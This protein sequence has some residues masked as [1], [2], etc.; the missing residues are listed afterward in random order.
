M[1]AIQ[2][3]D[4]L[5]FIW[6]GFYHDWTYNHRVNRMGD[7]ISD[8][9]HSN[10]FKAKFNHSAA[11]GI[12]GD[13]LSYTTFVTA[14]RTG[15]D[16]NFKAGTISTIVQ[17]SEGDAET[18]YVP[19]QVI[20][21]DAHFDVAD[22]LL[23]GFDMY[24][25][26]R[27]S[28][29]LIGDGQADKL[30]FLF[31]NFHEVEVSYEGANTIVDFTTRISVGG[32]CT[33]PECSNNNFFDYQV[34]V[35]YQ[36]I[37]GGSNE[38]MISNDYFAK[39]EYSW[40]RPMNAGANEIHREDYTKED[41]L[42]EGQPGFDLGFAG[43]ASVF[44]RTTKGLGGFDGT[45]LEYPHMLN[46]DMA[47]HNS[48]YDVTSGDLSLDVDVFFKNWMAPVPPLSFGA[49][50]SVQ[51]STKLKLIQIA[52]EEGIVESGSYSNSII[53]QTNPFNPAPP[54]GPASL[55]EVEVDLIV[56]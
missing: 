41:F 5:T 24:S 3:K 46:F 51:F 36:V 45:S 10:G 28:L 55:K 47:V 25:R 35:A 37:A 34:T 20:F 54:T 33:S 29:D 26:P 11:S 32:D 18:V 4:K 9:D 13:E 44:F 38:L 2:P 49:G 48:S 12:G 52:D 43:I 27:G 17:G 21:E 23:N 16:V 42:L 31:I 6:Q 19:I 1:E 39:S 40:Q 50:G 56:E 7:W 14:V 22:V 15:A 8:V 53:W 30:W